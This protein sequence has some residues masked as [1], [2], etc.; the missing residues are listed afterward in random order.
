M[1]INLV[2]G[3]MLES[4]LERDG[5][6]LSVNSNLLYMDVTGLRVGINTATPSSQLD[7]VGNASI[8]LNLDA[9]TADVGNI[10][11]SGNTVSAA[12]GDLILT[13]TGGHVSVNS[14]R[15]L[16]CLDPV[17]VLDV[18]NLQTLTSTVGSLT[19][20]RITLDNTTL[21]VID[22]GIAAGY[23]NYTIDGAVVGTYTSTLLSVPAL[24]ATGDIAGATA[25]IGAI[26]VTGDTIGT[27]GATIVI[28]A[29]DIDLTG[30]VFVNGTGTNKVLFTDAAGHIDGTAGFDYTAGTST[31]DLTGILNVDDLTL[32]AAGITANTAG[33]SLTTTADGDLT[34]SVGAG[35]I[36][37]QS[38]SAMQLPSGTTGERP[39]TPVAG[40]TRW[41]ETTGQPEYFDGSFWGTIAT[42]FA[43]T[44]Q[45]ITPAALTAG[46]FTIG[47][48]Y[49]IA[50]TGTTDFT[51]IGAADSNPGTVFTATGIGT[52][53]GTASS[54]DFVLNKAA[55]TDSILVSV[56]GLVQDPQGGAVYSVSSTTLTFTSILLVTDIVSVRFLA[57]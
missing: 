21:Q 20:D 34:V 36:D 37:L 5:I 28:D 46:F 6:D 23:F 14:K 17:G 2:S 12:T 19:N 27:T 54:F 44:S 51:T 3:K 48:T 50:T 40:M 52:G 32:D 18:V 24:N 30:N 42:T 35:L 25:T 39:V 7:V 8:S 38:S 55:T 1:A 22:D 53:T 47:F 43:I 10:T 31:F 56:N 26:T 57:I 49:Q 16:G 29:A 41:N 15:I 45:Q 9:N 4:D 13:S 33:M 11:L